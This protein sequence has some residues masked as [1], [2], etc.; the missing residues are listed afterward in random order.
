MKEYIDYKIKND[1]ESEYC[2]IVCILR[3]GLGFVLYFFSCFVSFLFVK[4]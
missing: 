4:F 3:I 2:V 1:I